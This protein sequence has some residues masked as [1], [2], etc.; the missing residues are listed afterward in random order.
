[1]SLARDAYPAG[2]NVPIPRSRALVATGPTRTGM[3]RVVAFDP[4]VGLAFLYPLSQLVVFDFIGQLFLMD[5]LALPMLAILLSLPGS[6]ERLQRIWPIL[7]MLA[8][9]LVGQVATDLVRG[10]VPTDFLRGWAKIGFFG[11]QLAVLWMWLPR[12]R[13]YFV[14]FALGLSVAAYFGVRE[15]FSGYEWKFGLDRALIF[16]SIAAL[17]IATMGFPRLRYLGP[18]LFVGLS[19]FLLAQAARSAF[20]T[21]F[22]AAVVLMTALLIPRIPALRRR[23]S[24]GTFVFLLIGGTLVATGA[25]TIY[26][27]AVQDG[28]LGRDAL[29]KYRDQTSGEV[30][31]ILGGRTES[32]VSVQAIADSPILG[33]GSWAKDP[34][35]VGLH[36]AMK[37]RYGLPVFESERG[38]NQLIPTHSHLFGAWVEA[39]LAGGL[40]WLWV[41]TMPFL[42]LY[43]LLKRNELLAPLVAY[44]AV[45]LLWSVLFSPFGSSERIFVAFQLTLLAWTM[46]AGGRSITLFAPLRDA[47]ARRS[48]RAS[49]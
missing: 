34:Y 14:A 45:A 17:I 38:K 32:L 20:G 22:I 25:T 28:L 23:L 1:M 41:L 16:F 39:G 5:L 44:C 10:S 31:L 21:L 40:F 36:H 24:G 11:L 8:I 18:A 26:G 4:W 35:Y 2:S 47:V 48:G 15:E 43:S 37:V 27:I 19:V 6:A 12:R 3:Q 9:W 46:R 13:Q 29:I 7:A 30:P 49:G 42:A 33:H